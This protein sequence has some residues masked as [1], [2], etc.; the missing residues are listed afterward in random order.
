MGT[1]C[2]LVIVGHLYKMGTDEILR[3]YVQD[4]ERH[5]ILAEANGGVAGGHYAHKATT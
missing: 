5:S 1:S 4:F 3:R 2:F